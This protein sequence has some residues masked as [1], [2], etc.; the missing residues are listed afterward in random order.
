MYYKISDKNIAILAKNKCYEN[1]TKLPSNT[2]CAC[3]M[4][5]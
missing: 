5:L 4:P 1:N 2:S 3:Y